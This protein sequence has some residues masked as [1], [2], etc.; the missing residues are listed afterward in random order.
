VILPNDD[1]G[2]G[3]CVVLLHAGVTDRRMWDEHLGPVSAAGYRV[4][5]MDLPGLGEA[6]LPQL[7]EPWCDVLATMD[8]LGVERAVL[9]GNSFGGAVAL[10][11][12]VVSPE[13]VEALVLVSAPPP[14]LEPSEQLREAWEAESAALTRGDIDAAV[15]AVLDAWTLADAPAALRE[16]MAA[17]QRRAFKLATAAGEVAEAPYPLEVDPDALG[18][19]MCPALVIAGGLEMADFRRGAEFLA[20]ELAN[21]RHVVIAEAGHLAPLEQPERFRELLLGFLAEVAPPTG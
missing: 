2:S 13:R 18:R 1:V 15:E 6:P 12:A 4:V 8:A 5:A 20:R 10:S 14:H 3:P 7:L 19:L 16:R 17:T 21:A 9:V 11:A